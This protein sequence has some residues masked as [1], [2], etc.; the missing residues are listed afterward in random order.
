MGTMN[1]NYI[2]N[3]YIN[4]KKFK[5]IN[6]GFVGCGYWATN[7]IKSLDEEKIKNINVFDVNSNKLKSLKKKFQNIKIFNS[8]DN[9]IKSKLDCIFLV[10]PQANIIF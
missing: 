7:L 9:L 5:S 3:D 6:V 2:K 10:T 4:L 1:K 8:L